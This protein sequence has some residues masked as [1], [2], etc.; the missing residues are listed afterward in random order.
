MPKWGL[1][2]LLA[3][4]EEKG[5]GG[6]FDRGVSFSCLRVPFCVFFS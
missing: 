1:R 4:E 6:W 2:L 3:Y 5:F